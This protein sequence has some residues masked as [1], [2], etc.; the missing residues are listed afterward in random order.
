MNRKIYKGRSSSEDS[1]TQG[2]A[3]PTLNDAASG[4]EDKKSPDRLEGASERRTG[5]EKRCRQQ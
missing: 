5:E 3:L 1:V 4:K 2:Y